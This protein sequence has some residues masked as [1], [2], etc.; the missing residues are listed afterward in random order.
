[1]GACLV[2]SDWSL[3]VGHTCMTSTIFITGK[4]TMNTENNILMQL[5]WD[6]YCVNNS[7]ADNNK[8]QIHACLKD[9]AQH[10]LNTN[11]LYLQTPVQPVL[12]VNSCK[13]LDNDGSSPQVSGLQSSVLTT[14]TLS[15]VSIT[16]HHPWGSLCLCGG[17]E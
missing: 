14:A 3:H 1:M 6:A 17:V 8:P 2:S 7:I 9:L 12:T 4:A 11:I 13:A 16:N 5:S 15:I 10:R